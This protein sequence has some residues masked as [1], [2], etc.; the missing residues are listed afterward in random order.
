MSNKQH[1]R[2]SASSAARWIACPP[3]VALSETLPPDEGGS[4][5][6]R[7]G[8]A[9]HELAEMKVQWLLRRDHQPD[10]EAWKENTSYYS[11]DMDR[12]T[13]TYADYVDFLVGD[14]FM[15]GT[16]PIVKTEFRVDFSRW[17]PDGFGTADCLILTRTI[18]YVIDYKHGQGV[19]V[20]ATGNP[21]LRLYALGA[22]ELL[23]PVY[24]IEEVVMTI[25]Q[26]RIDNISSETMAVSDLLEWADQTVIPAAARA[27]AGEGEYAPS[28]SACRWCRAKAVCRARAEQVLSVDFS[29]TLTT[30]E[31]AAILGRIPEI[32]RWC[33][34]MEAH[35]LSEARSGTRFPGW[36]LVTGQTR[37][38]VT[39]QTAAYEW[40]MGE[41]WEAGDVVKSLTLRS[42]TDLKRLLGPES[43]SE[44]K[45][46][47]VTAPEGAP[48]LVPETDRRPEIGSLDQAREE[49]GD[50]AQD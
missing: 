7:E 24:D 31:I 41:E 28:E 26:P 34:D 9:A 25:V 20:S 42:L 47:F 16:I 30:A 44:F 37:S 6:A 22:Y 2:L 8:T 5:Y 4:E 15:E 45:G 21:Q 23:S 49:F 38:R 36:K 43:W 13:D 17:V 40:L 27:I 46:R 32:K 50:D 3:S 11:E 18:L 10:I 14:I 19:P 29:D 33:T 39:D 12:A 35:A 1:A 48:T